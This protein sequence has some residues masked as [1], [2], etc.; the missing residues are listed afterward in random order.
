[1]TIRGYKPGKD[2]LVF[3][4]DAKGLS[5]PQLARI[6]FASPVGLPDGL[7]TAKIGPRRQLAPDALVKAANPPF[8]VSPQAA[9]AAP[10]STTCPV[11]PTSRARPAR[12]RT[13]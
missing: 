11:S 10:S 4:N 6:G 3:G 5:K 8:D 1:M 7:Y 9:P 12:S 13:A 2:K